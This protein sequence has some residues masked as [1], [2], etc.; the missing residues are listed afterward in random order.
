MSNVEKR[1][2]GGRGSCPWLAQGEQEESSV[3]GPGT[4][5]LLWAGES[6]AGTKTIS[7]HLRN[8]HKSN[9]SAGPILLWVLFF[10]ATCAEGEWGLNER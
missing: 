3:L 2:A 7:Q 8:E 10:A 5:L 9:T 1:R 6:R 4:L